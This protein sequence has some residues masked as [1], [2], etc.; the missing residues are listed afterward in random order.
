MKRLTFSVSFRLDERLGKI[1]SDR[2]ETGGTTP[3]DVARKM[4]EER[5][6]RNDEALLEGLNF[7]GQ[8]VSNL[9]ETMSAGLAQLAEKQNAQGQELAALKFAIN[10]SLQ[11]LIDQMS[12]QFD[13]LHQEMKDKKKC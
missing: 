8:M 7:L 5:L 9:Q 11:E 13:E 12:E 2:A 6:N 3:N 10:R 4:V 1:L